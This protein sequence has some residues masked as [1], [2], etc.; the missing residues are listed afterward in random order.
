LADDERV[1]AL[2][3]VVM[4]RVRQDMDD[5]PIALKIVRLYVRVH[6]RRDV[7]RELL[8]LHIDGAHAL[9][10]PDA[11][12][13]VAAIGEEL[14]HQVDEFID[15][16][17]TLLTCHLVLERQEHGSLRLGANGRSLLRFPID[18]LRCPPINR[19]PRQVAKRLHHVWWVTR[20]PSR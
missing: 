14:L 7:H 17:Q 12:R 15:E 11:H 19:P 5:R 16:A 1:A 6:L 2:D 13:K 10:G 8:S 20:D 3:E 18:R 9:I 4:R